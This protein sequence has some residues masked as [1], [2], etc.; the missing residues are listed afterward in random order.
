MKLMFDA[1]ARAT[2]DC[3]HWR[4]IALSVAPLVLMVVCTFAVGFFLWEPMSMQVSRWVQ[5]WPVL[6]GL[7]HQLARLGLPTLRVWFAPVLMLC[8][9]AP[10][11]VVLALLTVAL[12]VTPSMVR[13]VAD[14]RFPCLE[15]RHGGSAWMSLWG[16]IG[17]TALAGIALL[18]SI[19]LWF[20]PPLMVVIPPLIWGWLTY[21]VLGYDV[22]ADHA[23]SDERRELLRRHRPA[24]LAMG[25]ITG[26]LGAA[27][28]LVWVSGV[29]FVA[30]SPLLIPLAV[31]IYTLVFAFSSLWFAH[32]ALSALS[33]MRIA[34]EPLGRVAPR[35]DAAPPR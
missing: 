3:L 15:K 32:Y 4:V 30:L 25:V 13:R 10:I 17:A 22:L 24:L 6:S 8:V 20:V 29:V 26:Y 27:P 14:L 11:S 12:A 33:Q 28:S 34:H 18:A 31:W 35:M 2:A 1:L 16:G 21:R 7:D 19:P 23:S 5:D 9:A